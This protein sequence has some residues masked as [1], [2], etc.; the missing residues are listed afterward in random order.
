M[1][2]RESTFESDDPEVQKIYELTK[3][4]GMAALQRYLDVKFSKLKN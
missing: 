4:E 1:G 3:S 2:Q